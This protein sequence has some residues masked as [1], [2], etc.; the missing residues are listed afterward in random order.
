MSG[1]V[2]FVLGDRRYAAPVAHVREVVRL[3]A[4]A[5][6]PAMAP[7]TAGVLD[8]RGRPLPVVDLRRGGSARGDVLRDDAGQVFVVDLA[9]MLESVR[10]SD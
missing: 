3:P 2:L 1:Y 6:L 10:L 4:L 7:G 9:A 5:D 8:L